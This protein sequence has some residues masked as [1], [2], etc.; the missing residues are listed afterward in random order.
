[1][2]GTFGALNIWHEEKRLTY[3]KLLILFHI[4]FWLQKYKLIILNQNC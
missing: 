2:G 3:W 4:Y 1:M